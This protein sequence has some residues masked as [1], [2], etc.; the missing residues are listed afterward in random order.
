[1]ATHIIWPANLFRSVF[2]Y[3]LNSSFFLKNLPF[4][5]SIGDIDEA[6]RFWYIV[7]PSFV[8][9]TPNT[10]NLE[11]L[12]SCVPTLNILYNSEIKFL[13]N[14]SFPQN[15][16]SSTCIARIPVKLDHTLIIPLKCII[17]TEYK[18]IYMYCQNTRQV[19]PYTH[20]SSEMYHF[21]RI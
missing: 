13:W 11:V 20:Y 16:K 15:I 12:F 6:N 7:I 19:G 21:H 4:F 8:H 17:S 10:Q 3:W 2:S 1:M 14:V 18:I 9:L 5:M